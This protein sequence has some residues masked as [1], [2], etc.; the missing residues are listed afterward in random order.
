M[1]QGFL[2]KG[3]RI[4]APA[5]VQKEMMNIMQEKCFIA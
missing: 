4:I 3:D 2:S 5:D 1:G